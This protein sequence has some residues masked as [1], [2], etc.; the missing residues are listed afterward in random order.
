MKIVLI[1][2][3]AIGFLFATPK[4]FGKESDTLKV[5]D[6]APDFTLLSHDKQKVTLKDYRGKRVVVYFF[7]KADTPGW[8]KEAC[9]FRNAF[10]EYEKA[11]IIVFGI[12][13]D[14]PKAL[15]SFKKKHALPFTLLS[16]K[17]KDVSKAYG[18]KGRLWSSRVT[19]LISPK[20][21]I[22]K[23]YKKMNV[24]THAGEIL[25]DILGKK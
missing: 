20:G 25:D 4:I 11:N 24:N 7:P 23:I 9:G 19:F 5:G 8:T 17:R 10:S 21:R 13:Y 16:D 1:I 6:M 12:S 22:E 14:S 2:I 18:T 15:K 3:F